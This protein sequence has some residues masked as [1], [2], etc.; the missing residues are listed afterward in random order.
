MVWAVHAAWSSIVNVI[1]K[2]GVVEVTCSL[3][4]L[5]DYKG[6]ATTALLDC[7]DYHNL[8][9]WILYFTTTT[10]L[11]N[12]EELFHRRYPGPL[13]FT[14]FVFFVLQCSLTLWCINCIGDKSRSIVLE[15]NQLGVDTT[16]PVLLFLSI[17]H[18]YQRMV[19]IC[20]RKKLPRWDVRA[21]LPCDAWVE[22]WG[23]TT[24]SA[25][26]SYFKESFL[27][28]ILRWCCSMISFLVRFRLFDF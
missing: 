14:S 9:G 20:C 25:L 12:I 11:S 19:F 21:G 4:R 15:T 1:R 16:W 2:G 23:P 26:G 28:S 27:I 17:S 10:A 6:T 24:M 8:N 3:L 18:W 22:T 5:R 7:L 13:A